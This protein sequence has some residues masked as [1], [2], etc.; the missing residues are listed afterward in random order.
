M[1]QLLAAHRDVPDAAARQLADEVRAVMELPD[2]AP[3]FGPDA[4]AEVSVSGVVGGVG[5][6]GQIDRLHV[7]EARVLVADFK[8]GSRPARAPVEYRRQMALYAALLEQIYPDRQVVTWLVWTEDRSIEEIDR[9]A[10]DAAL[11]A[12]APG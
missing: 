8:T 2:L 3:V 6:A 9:T 5:V 12:M 10:R 4:L 1:E 11:A 7:D